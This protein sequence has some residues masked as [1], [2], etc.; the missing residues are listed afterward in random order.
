MNRIQKTIGRVVK[1]VMDRVTGAGLMQEE[2]TPEEF[3]ANP[4][5]PRLREFLSKVL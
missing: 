3:F 2:N 4:K 1:H 5:N